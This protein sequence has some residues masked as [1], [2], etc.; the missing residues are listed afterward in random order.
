MDYSENKPV[1]PG[2]SSFAVG[3][4]PFGFFD[5]D[6]EFQDHADKFAKYAA[7]HVGYPIM[8]VELQDVNFYT[9]FEASV[10]EYSNQVNQINITNNLVNTIGIKTASNFMP[11]DG[12]TGAVVGNSFGYITKLSKAYGTEAESGGNVKWYTASIDMVPGQQTYNLKT[13]AQSALATTLSDTDGIEVRRVI[14]NAP[15][16]LIRYFDPFVGTGL[17]SQQLYRV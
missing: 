8:D 6:T 5:N 16:A 11:A 10:I 3:K 14:H 4:T 12:L 15:P 2:S 1:W 13:A 17:G 7:Q 9:A